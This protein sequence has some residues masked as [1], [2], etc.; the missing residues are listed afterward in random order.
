METKMKMKFGG[1]AVAL[2]MAV[3][4]SA[5]AAPITTPPPTLTATGDVQAFYVFSDAADKS[6]LSLTSPSSFSPI[7]CNHSVGSCTA[8]T[9]GAQVDLGVLAGTIVFSLDNITQGKTYFS[10]ALDSDGNSHVLITNDFTDLGLS[11]IPTSLS[12][13]ITANPSV[14]VVYIGWEDRNKAEHSDFDY[15]DLI[16][17]F[18]NVTRK[19]PVGTPEPATLA[20]LGAG[21]AGLGLARRRRKA[22]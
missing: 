3:C 11:S 16:F 9:A 12:N 10:D 17:A 22:A 1:M 18:T 15:N 14:E 8:S 4:G 2:A 19:P 21:L 5:A 13:Y 6:I 7:F 20:L